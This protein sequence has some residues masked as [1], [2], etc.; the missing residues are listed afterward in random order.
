[1]KIILS[2][3]SFMLVLI[4]CTKIKESEKNNK[5]IDSLSLMKALKENEI[6][7]RK[8]VL[9]SLKQENLKKDSLPKLDNRSLKEKSWDTFLINFKNAVNQN[10]KEKLI[11]MTA[12]HEEFFSGGGGESPTE[13]FQQMFTYAPDK[14]D[15]QTKLKGRYLDYTFP[16]SSESNRIVGSGKVEAGELTFQFVNG[17]WMFSGIVGD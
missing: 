12:K 1:M 15:F 17:K 6:K 11:K 8:F 13:F 5:D 10:N 4:S 14:K 2:A 3:L 9:D 7:T 16:N